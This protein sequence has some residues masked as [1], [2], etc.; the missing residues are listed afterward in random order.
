MFLNHESE[1]GRDTIPQTTKSFEKK[2]NLKAFSQFPE[3][4]DTHLWI[5]I[6][7]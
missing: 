5:N 4:M 2:L 1:K 7:I 6:K 3:K